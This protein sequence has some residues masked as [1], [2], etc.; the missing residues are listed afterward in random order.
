MQE[1]KMSNK[2]SSSTIQFWRGSDTVAS[3][4]LPPSNVRTNL[5]SQPGYRHSLPQLEDFIE[6]LYNIFPMNWNIFFRVLD[7][8]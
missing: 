8:S 6:L 1:M 2:Q 5:I 7:V 3:M 4:P